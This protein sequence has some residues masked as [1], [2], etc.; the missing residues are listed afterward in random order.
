MIVDWTRI[1]AEEKEIKGERK[2]T[3]GSRRDL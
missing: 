3:W 1:V 2:R